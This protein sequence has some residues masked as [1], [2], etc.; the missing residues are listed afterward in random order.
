[1]R[2]GDGN[3][4]AFS[5]PNEI[6]AS[7]V[8]AIVS[9]RENGLKAAI[10]EI[11]SALARNPNFRLGHQIRGD[12]LMARAG[13]PIAFGAAPGPTASV[14]HLQDE[15]RVRLKRYLDAPPVDYLPAPVLQLAPSQSH[16]ILVD[17]G[18]SRLYVFENHGGRPRYV[19]DFYI[20]LGKNGVEKQREGD[21]KTPIG[22]Y[23][24][25]SASEKLPDFYGTLA[26]PISYPNEWDKRH[27]R[28]GHGIW[29]HGT[30]SDT[31][32]RPPFATDG[33]VVLT[34]DDLARLTRFVNVGRT[35]VVIGSTVDWKD[36]KQWEAQREDFL[37]A[38]AQW[39]VDW[40]SLD[41]NRYFAHYGADFR[42]DGKDRA[43]WIAQKRKVGAGKSW[44]KVG[45][46]QVSVFGY[47]GNG[48]DDDGHLRAGLPLEQPLEPHQQAPVL[49]PRGQPLAHRPR[50][51]R[52]LK[53]TRMQFTS[54]LAR[55]RSSHRLRAGRLRRPRPGRQAR[56]LRR[57]AEGQRTVERNHAR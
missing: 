44:V 47:P 55:P 48:P 22:V 45:V 30:P 7:L 49:G 4:G 26:F 1:M 50:V 41:I 36:P 25:V 43:A 46:S 9:L 19:T 29:L 37:A 6:E 8:R 35:P 53:G 14:S 17:T 57:Q 24:V 27:G 40:E 10:G 15:A 20:S 16:A 23:T 21:Q 42:T 33:C 5:F 12:L 54:H 2:D 32:S 34:N 3:G 39:R 38:F 28:N 13:K 52:F 18:R 11:D 56:R 31:Y 51:R